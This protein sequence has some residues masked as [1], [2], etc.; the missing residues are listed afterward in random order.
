MV[1]IK[2][3]CFSDF[4]NSLTLIQAKTKTGSRDHNDRFLQHSGHKSKRTVF[5]FKD[6]FSK[7]DHLLFHTQA[8]YFLR[9]ARTRLSH[10]YILVS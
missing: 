2:V 7:G 1:F 4:W 10:L 6:T 9:L 5:F 8:R 3:V